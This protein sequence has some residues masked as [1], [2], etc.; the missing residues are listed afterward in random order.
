MHIHRPL[1]RFLGK[2]RF[3]KPQTPKTR[4]PDTSKELSINIHPL[5]IHFHRRLL[6][7]EEIEAI[8][9]GGATTQP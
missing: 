6:T 4:V 3:I 8:T 7:P 1:I 9:S 2:N 5:P